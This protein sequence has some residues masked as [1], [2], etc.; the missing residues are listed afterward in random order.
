MI[1]V[2]EMTELFRRKQTNCLRGLAAL[3]IAI[4][5]I[6][7]DWHAP[8]VVNITGSVG[9]AMFLVLSGYGINES[10]KKNGLN[11]Y[12]TK[13]IKRIII[14][15]FLFITTLIPFANDFSLKDY[16]LD[17]TFIDSSFWY[18][19]FLMKC[20]VFY[21]IVQRFFPDKF[22]ILFLIG[23]LISLNF[24]MQMEAEQSFSFFAGACISKY[25]DDIQ[26]IE[27]KKILLFALYCFLFGFF[28]LMLKEIPA[29]HAY[30]GTKLY[31]YI[32]LCIKLPICTPLLLL[33]TIIPII[34]K[35]KF[36]YICGICSFELYLVHLFLLR[37]LDK[38]FQGL[39]LYITA[40]AILTMA[41][42][43]INKM[44]QRL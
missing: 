3:L 41:F 7:I 37:Y 36:L 11:K 26:T 23:G 14:P 32:L 17:I 28:F 20:Y 16:L 13:K 18:V 22:F 30:K 5:H 29:V 35:S 21:W 10:Y 44:I 25:R 42:Y 15:Y 38:S 40:T 19:S 9:V 1:E 6:L 31:N 34:E 8:R 33:P 27:K 2:Q 4:G 24:L 39:I 43:K 12:W